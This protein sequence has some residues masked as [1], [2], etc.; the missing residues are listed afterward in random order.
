MD[1][2]WL[3][4]AKAKAKDLAFQR[5]LEEGQKAHVQNDRQYSRISPKPSRE[6]SSGT[7]RFT[8]EACASAPWSDRVQTAA[9]VPMEGVRAFLHALK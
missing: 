4:K 7:Q 1:G 8:T 9:R 6:W 5:G 3:A 2:G